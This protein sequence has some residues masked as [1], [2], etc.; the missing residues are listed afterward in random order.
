MSLSDG[1][2]V[3]GRN[4]ARKVVR[5]KSPNQLGTLRSWHQGDYGRLPDN[6]FDPAAV[7]EHARLLH[8]HYTAHSQSGA[9]SSVQNA[10]TPPRGFAEYTG[11]GSDWEHNVKVVLD[12]INKR[13]YL[14]V[15]HYQYW[16]LILSADLLLQL[17]LALAVPEP[18]SGAI[19]CVV[20]G[21][22]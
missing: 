1:E 11:T 22:G 20:S 4:R 3:H 15:A 21:V 5:D 8:A 12:Y 9:G 17:G 16:A 19:R 10:A 2:R 7:P 6:Q 13:V 14:T 18:R